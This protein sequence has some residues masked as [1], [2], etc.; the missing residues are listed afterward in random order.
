MKTKEIEGLVFAERDRALGKP[1]TKSEP[2]AR[3]LMET[4]RRA[5]RE[6][7]E[8]Q[9]FLV[10]EM[11]ELVWKHTGTARFTDV[12]VDELGWN[13]T[14]TIFD[15]ELLGNS[16]LAIN[17]KRKSYFRQE[18]EMTCKPRGEENYQSSPL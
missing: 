9:M 16:G 10:M 4:M 6:L 1:A 17:I 7:I 11:F 5:R 12:V 8:A 18:V 3:N 14:F 2:S 13:A 15:S